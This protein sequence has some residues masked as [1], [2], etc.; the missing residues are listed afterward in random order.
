MYSYSFKVIKEIPC[1]YLEA[2]KTSAKISAGL[3]AAYIIYKII[4]AVATWEYGGCG[5]LGPSILKQAYKKVCWRKVHLYQVTEKEN[6]R[7]SSYTFY[8]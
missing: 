2:I 7:V 8:Q 4:V 6:K 1:Y 3:T 5:V